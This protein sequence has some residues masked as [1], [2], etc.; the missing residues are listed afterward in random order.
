LSAFSSEAGAIAADLEQDVGGLFASVQQS[1]QVVD[2]ARLFAERAL[3]YAERA[4]F[5]FRL[6]ARLGVNEIL[7]DASLSLAQLSVPPGQESTL[8]DLM[9]ELQQTLVI[10]RATLG[11]A[12]LTVKSVNALM[13][14][15]S[16]NPEAADSAKATIA[17]LAILLKEWN[18]LLS[19][20]ANQKGISQM[21]GIASQMEM[22]SNRFLRRLAWLGAGLILFFWAMYVLSKLVYQFV[23]LKFFANIKPA[24]REKQEG[25]KAA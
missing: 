15:L 20:A 5:L 12:N 3:Y 6:Q 11:D 4:P 14:Q 24:P 23:L 19:S 7:N 9:K 22:Q 21:A 10:T 2:S 17:Q 13:N 1:T 18:Q 25:K 16:D 8:K